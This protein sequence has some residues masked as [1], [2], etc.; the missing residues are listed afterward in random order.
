MEGEGD[1][2]YDVDCSG[3]LVCDS[4]C[5]SAFPDTHDCCQPAE[6]NTVS[7]RNAPQSA[8]ADSDNYTLYITVGAVLMF[9]ILVTVKVRR[10][11]RRRQIFGQNA[12]TPKYKLVAVPQSHL[13]CAP[14]NQNKDAASEGA[15]LNVKLVSFFLCFF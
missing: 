13:D 1:C 3:S 8:S 2:D 12:K 5:D 6:N 7:T 11:R 10:I 9:V 14:A 15:P 4:N